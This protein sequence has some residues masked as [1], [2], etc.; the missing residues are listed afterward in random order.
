LANEKTARFNSRFEDKVEKLGEVASCEVIVH[1]YLKCI[2]IE[3][4]EIINWM[5]VAGSSI[6]KL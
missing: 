5:L 6:N 4:V 1:L 3:A 2:A